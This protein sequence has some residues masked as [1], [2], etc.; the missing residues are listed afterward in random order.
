MNL[1]GKNIASLGK[2]QRISPAPEDTQSVKVSD[3][4]NLSKSRSLNT[5]KAYREAINLFK[6]CNQFFPAVFTYASTPSITQANRTLY[7]SCRGALFFAVTDAYLWCALQAGDKNHGGTLTFN[8]F[9]EL[10]EIPRESPYSSR[11]MEIFGT[12]PHC[13]RPLCRHSLSVQILGPWV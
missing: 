10:F 3:Y 9:C 2:F 1:A 5:Q 12:K 11:I 6:V 8:E 13:V 7:I 4:A